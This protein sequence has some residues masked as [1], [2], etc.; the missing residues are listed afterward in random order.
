LPK[1]YFFF[2]VFFAAFLAGAFFAA[3]F[4]V[5]MVVYSPFSM[6]IESATRVCSYGRYM[7]LEK[8]CQEKNHSSSDTS[9]R[10]NRKE[11][12]G[13]GME[14]RGRFLFAPNIGWSQSISI[15]NSPLEEPF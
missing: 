13:I 5:A 6:C 1:D 11:Q 12:R 8:R 7:V 15:T 4:A 10:W 9:D 3:F 14:V 2:A